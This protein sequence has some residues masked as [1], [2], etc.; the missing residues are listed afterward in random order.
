MLR[1]ALVTLLLLVLLVSACRKTDT[2]TGPQGA[3]TITTTAL[4]AGTQGAAYVQVL[5]A[6]GGNGSYTWSLSTGSLPSGLSL[7]SSTGEING[8]PTTVE[9]RSFGIRADSDGADPATR[10][11]T[12]DI[13]DDLPAGITVNESS[14]ATVVSEAATVD[15]LTVV[16]E[17]QP[18][19]NVVLEVG[20][21]DAAEVTV[22]PSALTFTNAN[23]D[24]PQSV[25]VT[26]VDDAVADGDQATDVTISVRAANSDA[27]YR[28]VGD[29]TVSVTTTDDESV[30]AG[31]VWTWMAGDSL[32]DELA[33]YGTLGV[34][35]AANHPGARYGPA[36][37]VQS[38]G[39]VW[40]FGGD[41]YDEGGARD[42]LND[43]WRFDG[44]NWTWMAGTNLHEQ[45]GDYGT[46]GVGGPT[47]TPGARDQMATGMGPDEHLWLF[48]GLGWGATTTG[49]LADLWRFDGTNWIYVRGVAPNRE[50]EY[51]SKGSPNPLA[52][53][54]GRRDAT[55][56]V[57]DS[58]DVWLFGG[59]GS[60]DTGFVP[61]VG[62]EYGLVNDLWR[63]DG[64]DWAWMAGTPDLNRPGIYGTQ[65][66]PDPA[67][68]P[69]ARLGAV[70]WVDGDGN[71]WLY[72]GNGYAEGATRS[73]PLTDLWRF[74]GTN[75]TWMDGPSTGGGLP[76]WGTPGVP[77]ASNSPGP[78]VGSPAFVDEAGDFWLVGGS[79]RSDAWRYDGSAWT[80][81]AGD[82]TSVS[83]RRYGTVG[84]PSSG[85]DPGWRRRFAAGMDGT[86]AIWL[87]GGSGSN[88]GMGV[89][90]ND[91][92][93]LPTNE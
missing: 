90:L 2:P 47:T 85:N 86:G 17:A 78:R 61:G 80:W 72:G 62:Q 60:G 55:M 24:E 41:G 91:L 46:P 36:G 35:D 15:S 26:G 3:V 64:T 82:S 6:S 30:A 79:G 69:G 10:E 56:W 8:T 49:N 29:E 66:V 37:W 67:N 92:W 28:S 12:I 44:T 53:P 84:V 88:S 57:D 58:G 19:S 75:W 45:F 1:S 25:I 76:T 89:V 38:N 42:A 51:F 11:F 54:G 71:L 40:I 93:R 68:T 13:A 43:L 4:P 14:G 70:G 21:A 5:S 73:T 27:R 20:S 7:D 50:G 23:W 9:S 52:F 87:F 74:D 32:G 59:Y 18:I 65:G 81:M 77:S 31:L 16:L 39:H 48:G 63:F 22:T 34:P 33:A 83:E